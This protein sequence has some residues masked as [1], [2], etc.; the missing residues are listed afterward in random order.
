MFRIRS[1]SRYDGSLAVLS[2][3]SS[4]SVSSADRRSSIA[5][6]LAVALGAWIA[7]VA[8]VDGL[9]ERPGL[10]EGPGLTLDEV[11]NI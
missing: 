9:G 1:R 2:Q 10:P 3:P 8:T 6:P 5:G 4:V 7:V 11:F